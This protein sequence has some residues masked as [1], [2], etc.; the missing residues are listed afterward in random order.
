[1]RLLKRQEKEPPTY[2]AQGKNEANPIID[3]EYQLAPFGLTPLQSKIYLWLLC[4]GPTKAS[5]L[6]K[7]LGIHRA[8]VYRV[9]R[10]LVSKGVVEM[11]MGSPAIYSAVPS[12]KAL[13]IFLREQEKKLQELKQR[14]E[15]LALKIDKRIS[16]VTES[17][18]RNPV[19]P[20]FMSSFRLKFGVQVL[21]MW[22]EMLANAKQEVLRIWSKFGISYHD[23]EGLMEEYQTCS[24][25]G[26]KIRAVTEIDKDTAKLVKK[27]SKFIE[28]RHNVISASALRYTIVD[29]KQ[30]FVSTTLVPNK[31]EDF[32]ALW[33]DNSALVRGFVMDFEEV[34]S[35]SIQLQTQFSRMGSLKQ[36]KPLFP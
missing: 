24:Q 1:M 31:T 34:W 17:S 15:T 18:G 26:V 2:E 23:S 8:D 19:S 29:R 4:L 13:A 27:Y 35:K 20:V 6:I 30:V 3:L 36:E 9:L 7:R 12:T 21:E 16:E 32:S 5:N 11:N 28:F 25:R 10:N 14:S 33:T 22:R